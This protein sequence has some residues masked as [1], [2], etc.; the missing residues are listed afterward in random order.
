MDGHIWY[1]FAREFKDP[2]FLWA[3]EQVCLG[4]RPPQGHQV[5]KQYLEAYKKRYFWFIERGIEPKVPQG[6]SGISY[7]SPLKH[8]IPERLY[9]CPSRESG[10]PFASFFIYDRN[11]NYMHYC[12]DSDGKLYEY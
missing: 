11:N 3:S 6:G 4:G 1:L 8:K 12:D 5:P 2:E 9:L 10:Q 7:Y